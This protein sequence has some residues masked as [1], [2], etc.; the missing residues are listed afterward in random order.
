MKCLHPLG[1]RQASLLQNWVDFLTTNFQV[2]QTGSGAANYYPESISGQPA[3]TSDFI[4]G[5]YRPHNH[6]RSSS[7]Y[8]FTIP[9]S[10]NLHFFH[11]IF[12]VLLFYIKYLIQINDALICIA[13]LGSWQKF[14]KFTNPKSSNINKRESRY[15]IK[16]T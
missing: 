13:H 3:A 9:E 1:I 15:T 7:S 5:T 16:D 10:R 8:I 6:H 4:Y 2:L 11:E 14:L 12:F